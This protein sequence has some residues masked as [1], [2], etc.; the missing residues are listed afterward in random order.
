MGIRSTSVVSASDYILVTRAFGE[1]TS[2][3]VLAADPLVIVGSAALEGDTSK[4]GLFTTKTS[5]YNFAQ[6]VRT[7]I[8]MTEMAIATSTRTSPD[9]W[10]FEKMKAGNEHKLKI[11]RALLF[12]ERA[13][14]YSSANRRLATRGLKTFVASANRFA[15]GGSMLEYDF[16]EYLRTIF[17]NGSGDQSSSTKI[18]LV[19]D[20]FATT[21]ARFAKSRVQITNQNDTSYGVNITNYKVPQGTLKIV[22]DK[23][24]DEVYTGT[25]YALIYDPANVRLRYFAG[26]Q[27][28]GRTKIY[29]NI[30]A[31]DATKR[32]DEYRTTVGLECRQ[33]TTHGEIS[34]V[35]N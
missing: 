10:A 2:A 4:D 30:Q 26:S 33:A 18:A 34:G 19:N 6:E 5:V 3:T 9:A 11:E 14:A 12:G 7:P 24:L 31:N 16:D 13:S 17:R 22:Y 20:L 29:E 23:L 35:T 27:F 15:V 8:E 1:T 32:K 21:V 28:N 25:G